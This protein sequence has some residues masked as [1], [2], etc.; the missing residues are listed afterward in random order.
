MKPVTGFVGQQGVLSVPA[1]CSLGAKPLTDQTPHSSSAFVPG[2][3]ISVG[4]MDKNT[5]PKFTTNSGQ[6]AYCRSEPE[7]SNEF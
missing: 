4:D 7:F 5:E 1:A 6:R 2:S 3:T